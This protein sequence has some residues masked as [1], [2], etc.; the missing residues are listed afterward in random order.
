MRSKK[1]FAVAIAPP[2]KMATS[3]TS[4]FGNSTFGNTAGISA[5]NQPIAPAAMI[6]IETTRATYR[7]T[8]VA[9]W[10]VM[11]RSNLPFEY[12]RRDAAHKSVGNA[13][14]DRKSVV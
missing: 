3:W 9:D 2:G 12:L 8:R 4:V 14:L 1:G 13:A 7:L 10:P 5:S 11:K 6:R